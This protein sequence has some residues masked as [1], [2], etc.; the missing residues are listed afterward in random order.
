MQHILNIKEKEVAELVEL[1]S[2]IYLKLGFNTRYSWTFR[3][4]QKCFLWAFY[5]RKK[6]HSPRAESPRELESAGEAVH[7]IPTS[8]HLGQQVAVTVELESRKGGH[9][10]LSSSAFSL[11]CSRACAQEIPEVI[12]G[13]TISVPQ[14]TKSETLAAVRYQT[15][16]GERSCEADWGNTFDRDV[17]RRNVQTQNQRQFR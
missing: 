4:N 14:A 5:E 2:I 13:S 15:P 6:L 16:G 10:T 1:L 9:M 3:M 17:G 7:T 11:S 12:G 8:Q